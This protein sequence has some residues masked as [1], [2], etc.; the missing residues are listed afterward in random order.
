MKVLVTGGAGFI[1]TLLVNKLVEMGHEVVVL[2]NLAKGKRENV[3]EKAVFIGGDVRDGMDV[4]KAMDGCAVVFHLAA[5]SDVAGDEDAIYKTNFLGSKNV[6]EVAKAKNAK[7]IFASSA[8]VYGNIDVP[9]RETAECKPLSQYGKSKLRSE[10]YLETL[11][12]N[13]SILRLFN[14]YGPKG[15]GVINKFAKQI[16]D[17]KDVV[18]NGNGMQTRDYVFVEDVVDAFIFAM[19]NNVDL[20]NVGTGRETSL[21]TV[22]DFIHNT[23][24]CKPT[25]KFTVQRSGEIFRSKAD[26]KKM[27]ELG[28]EP[29]I[30]LEDGIKMILDSY[31]WKPI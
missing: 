4:R 23:T 8:A 15:G 9:H 24:R 20:C 28:W 21:S 2:D 25:V 3:N 13:Y 18:I 26:T 30:Q 22:V 10:K 29:K 16:I 11:G 27:T 19:N 6:F 1:G 5:I 12:M 17:Y 31:G 14:V 7:I